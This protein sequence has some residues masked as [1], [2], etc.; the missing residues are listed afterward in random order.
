VSEATRKNPGRDVRAKLADLAASRYERLEE[1]LDEALES[2]KESW[3][4]CPHCR[5]KHEVAVPDWNARLRVVETLL[6]QGF[7]RPPQGDQES[8]RGFVLKRVVVEP[9]GVVS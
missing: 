8:E 5:R 3:V 9:N 1:F 2:E 7:G 6:N 4:A